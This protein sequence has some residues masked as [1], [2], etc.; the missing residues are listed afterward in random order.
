VLQGKLYVAERAK[1]IVYAQEKFQISSYTR[2]PDGKD[3]MT[4]WVPC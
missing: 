1:N 4:A 2:L 3:D